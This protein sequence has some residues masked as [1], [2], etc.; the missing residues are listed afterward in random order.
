MKKTT[1]ILVFFV[2]FISCKRDVIHAK[3]EVF[4]DTIKELPLRKDDF[5]NPIFSYKNHL[6]D[7]AGNNFEEYGDEIKA[8]TIKLKNNYTLIIFPTRVRGKDSLNYRLIGNK[9]DTIFEK[10]EIDSE[11]QMPYYVEDVDF[12]YYFTLQYS[13]NTHSIY[14][15]LYDKRSG[16]AVFLNNYVSN[17]LR[18]VDLKKELLIFEDE[19]NND[20]KYIYDVNTKTKTFIDVDKLSTK[21]K[22]NNYSVR[23]DLWQ[24]NWSALYVKR[25]SNGYYYLGGLS[26][27][28]PNKEFKLKITT[29]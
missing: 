26:D 11:N 18:K 27:C 12:R 29:P 4:K 5:G 23:C 21:G 17:V 28:E 20:K 3:N 6:I 8:D 15:M 22:N 25:I 2:I 1:I 24:N 16:K 13:L 14:F 7:D 19:D 10:Y 9:V